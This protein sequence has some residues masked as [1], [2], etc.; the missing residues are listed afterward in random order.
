MNLKDWPCWTKV[1]IAV[2]LVVFMLNWP[3]NSGE[4]AAWIQA[5]GSIGAIAGAVWVFSKQASISL[6]R[7]RD[8]KAYKECAEKKERVQKL[9]A[10]QRLIELG[11]VGLAS[12]CIDTSK[13]AIVTVSQL[14]AAMRTHRKSFE[15]GKEILKGIDL[16]TYPNIFLGLYVVNLR[17]QANRID[18]AIERVNVATTIEHVNEIK[19]VLEAT[20]AAVNKLSEEQ[21]KFAR[22]YD[23]GTDLSGAFTPE[24]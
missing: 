12:Y 1:S 18:Q 13:V 4:W 16:S 11:A 3:T 19:G 20:L 17:H 2:G 23:G 24:R 21:A 7:D 15:L 9:L 22:D 8:E 10:L 6:K 14:E 5:F